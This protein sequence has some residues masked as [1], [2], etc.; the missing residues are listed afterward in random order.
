MSFAI[1]PEFDGRPGSTGCKGDCTPASRSAG[2]CGCISEP[3]A[4]AIGSLADN[5]YGS[6]ALLGF[7]DRL[8]AG[9]EGQRGRFA[10][11]DAKGERLLAPFHPSPNARAHLSTHQMMAAQSKNA[12][13]AHAINIPCR[14]CSLG[15]LAGT[16]PNCLAW[17]VAIFSK[18]AAV[19]CGVHPCLS[20]AVTSA[21]NAAS[22]ATSQLTSRSG[23]PF[24]NMGGSTVRD[25]PHKATRG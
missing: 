4:I 12:S 17:S 2:S 23:L 24:G 16:S 7:H 11:I 5:E 20:E 13:A 8:M 15:G 3:P 9:G 1:A 19:S 6:S 21:V 25:I 18:A 14:V 10:K 22:K